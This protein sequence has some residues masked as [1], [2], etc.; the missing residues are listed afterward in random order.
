MQLAVLFR[1]ISH[2]L[3]VLILGVMDVTNKCIFER[4]Q[5]AHKHDRI[6]TCNIISTQQSLKLIHNLQN[7]DT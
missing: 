2:F 3:W 7:W 1:M 6:Y 4:Y 5:S